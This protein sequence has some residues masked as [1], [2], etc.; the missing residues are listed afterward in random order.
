MSETVIHKGTTLPSS[1]DSSDDEETVTTQTD[2]NPILKFH[3]DD[4]GN[5]AFFFQQPNK[6]VQNMIKMIKSIGAIEKKKK[7]PLFCHV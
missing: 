3:K 2:S 1:N 7:C 6:Y 5:M 4:Q